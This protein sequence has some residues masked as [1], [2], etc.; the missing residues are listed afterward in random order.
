MGLHPHYI[1]KTTDSAFNVTLL[2]NL[3]VVFYVLR[4]TS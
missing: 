4:Q 1:G 3:I 2:E